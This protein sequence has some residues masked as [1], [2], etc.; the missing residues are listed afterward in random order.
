MKDKGWGT[1]LC[2]DPDDLTYLVNFITD[3]ILNSTKEEREKLG[4]SDEEY[5]SLKE[6]E[7]NDN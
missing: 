1:R 6:E 5:N 7:E 2:C 3:Y 4:I